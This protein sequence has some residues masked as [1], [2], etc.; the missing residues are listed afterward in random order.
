MLKPLR[1]EQ[2][3]MRKRWSD[4]S[5]QWANDSALRRKFD[6]HQPKV[7]SSVQ[8]TGREVEQGAQAEDAPRKEGE[9]K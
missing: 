8:S 3:D 2:A 1:E 4:P 7:P 9:P 6:R 5:Y